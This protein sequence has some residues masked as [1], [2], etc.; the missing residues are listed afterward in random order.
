MTW[1][2]FDGS[3]LYKRINYYIGRKSPS[4]TEVKP[5]VLHVNVL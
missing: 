3:L 2:F 4:T 5:P 1:L